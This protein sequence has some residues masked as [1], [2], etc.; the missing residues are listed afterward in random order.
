MLE[1]VFKHFESSF[2]DQNMS[3]GESKALSEHL[4]A[5]KGT[6]KNLNVL[7]AKIFDLANEKLKSAQDVKVVEWLESSMKLLMKYMPNSEYNAEVYFSPGKDCQEQIIRNIQKARSEIRICVFT[8]SDN[9]IVDELIECSNRGVE[10]TIITDNDKMMDMGSD[11]Q[12]MADVGIKTYIDTTSNHMHHK[13]A[14]FDNKVLIS[15]SY[16]WTRSAYKYNHENITV[17]DDVYL[18]Q[19]FSLEFEK[20]LDEMKA[21]N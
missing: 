19:Q 12:K 17:Q 7:R 9:D 1:E 10:I 4:K 11:I 13:F 21:I 3:R 16:N 15:G 14:I 2:E 8:I 5:I 18:V 6:K 20:L